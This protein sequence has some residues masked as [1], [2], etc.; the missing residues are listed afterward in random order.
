MP[1]A[2]ACVEWMALRYAASAFVSWL[3]RLCVPVCVFLCVAVYLCVSRCDYYHFELT[4]RR[5]V[6]NELMSPIHFIINQR[7]CLPFG[8]PVGGFGIAA[9]LYLCNGNMSTIY[10]GMSVGGRK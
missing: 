7:S 2:E 3:A 1:C 5:V 6:A 8:G 9:G 4:T 10:A